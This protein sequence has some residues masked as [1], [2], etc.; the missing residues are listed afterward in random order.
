MF[1]N[2]S[3][4]FFCIL[5]AFVLAATSAHAVEP[6]PTSHATIHCEG[7]L[8]NEMTA[9]SETLPTKELRFRSLT[10]HNRALPPPSELGQLGGTSFRVKLSDGESFPMLEIEAVSAQG[11]TSAGSPVYR[12]PMT[13]SYRSTTTQG[14]DLLV[15]CY[16]GKTT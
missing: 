13:V 6:A 15:E 9:R 5:S 7:S 2:S 10:R 12:V 1:T 4:V 8:V 14:D 3:I 16:I 11:A